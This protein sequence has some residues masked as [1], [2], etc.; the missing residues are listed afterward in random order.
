MA[1][2]TNEYLIIKFQYE[3]NKPNESSKQVVS[4]VS[5]A[6]T[7]LINHPTIPGCPHL[8]AKEALLLPKDWSELT[9]PIVVALQDHHALDKVTKSKVPSWFTIRTDYKDYVEELTSPVEE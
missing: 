6:E 4:A 8:K 9:D 5:I 7:H 2:N 1:A 3:G